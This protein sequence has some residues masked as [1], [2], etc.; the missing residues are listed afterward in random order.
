MT[1]DDT[2]QKNKQF[3][4]KEKYKNTN[5]I[6]KYIHKMLISINTT[7]INQNDQRR[8]LEVVQ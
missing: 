6:E 8:D 7:Q 2:F 4:I 3:D 1:K 5:T